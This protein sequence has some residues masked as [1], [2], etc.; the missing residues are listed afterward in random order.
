MIKATIHDVAKNAGVSVATV[1]HVINGTHYV[2]PE[3][4]DRVYESINKLNYRQNK[5]ARALSRNNIPL[6][7]LIVPDISNPYWSSLARAV[8]DVTDPYDYSVIVCSSDGILDREIRFL[9]SLSGWVS[10]LILHPYHVSQSQVNQLILHNLPAVILGEFTTSEKQPSNWDQVA[11]NNRESAMAAVEYLIGLGHRR[12]AFVQGTAGTP[13]SVKRMTGFRDALNSAGLPVDDNLIIPGD[14]TRTGGRRAMAEL[15][16]RPEPP[17]AVVCANDFSALGALEEAQLRGLKVPQSMSIVGYDDID[18]A[19]LASPPLT[20][21]RLPPHEI[22]VVAAEK[23]V[24]RLKGRVESS[25]A[26]IKGELIVRESTAGPL[27]P[28]TS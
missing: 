5:L 9:R 10:G 7:A 14:Y 18:E 2:S 11:A 12:I 6:L 3:L 26:T 17:T 25:H 24:E 16:N 19:A 13:S 1:S 28:S 4:A 15:L 27:Q 8:Q 20:T 21:I 23:L 22:G